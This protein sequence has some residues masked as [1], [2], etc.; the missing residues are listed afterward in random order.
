MFVILHLLI[1][2]SHV[3]ECLKVLGVRRNFLLLGAQIDKLLSLLAREE[4]LTNLVDINRTLLL[5]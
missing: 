3:F 5:D 1:Q 4:I 2:V